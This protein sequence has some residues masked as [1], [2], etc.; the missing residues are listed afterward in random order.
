MKSTVIL[1]GGG[2]YKFFFNIFF[3]RYLLE[4]GFLKNPNMHLSNLNLAYLPT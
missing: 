3:P 2:E 1:G 4:S